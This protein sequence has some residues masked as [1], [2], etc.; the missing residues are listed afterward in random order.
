MFCCLKFKK[1]IKIIHYATTFLKRHAVHEINNSLYCAIF[2]D[3]RKKYSEEKNTQNSGFFPTILDIQDICHFFGMKKILFYTKFWFLFSRMG[4]QTIIPNGIPDSDIPNGIPT[5]DSYPERDPDF[6]WLSRLIPTISPDLSE[7]RW[8]PILI[9]SWVCT[10]SV[11]GW[12]FEQFLFR[13]K[14]GAESATGKMDYP[15]WLRIS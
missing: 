14:S 8:D 11:F 3:W 7:S 12:W 10:T 13:L 6:Y 1:R 2:R 9:F 4:S 15:I 5:S